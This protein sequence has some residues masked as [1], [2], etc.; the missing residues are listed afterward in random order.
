MSQLLVAALAFAL[1]QVLLSI[2]LLLRS[3]QR[4]SIQARLFLVFL[5]GVCGYL[6]TPLITDPLGLLWIS[7][8]QTVA[9]GTFWLFSASLFDDHFRLRP[10]K[11]GVVALTVLMPFI[12]TLTKLSGGQVPHWFFYALP[13]GI[14]FAL[15][16]MAL[17]EVVRCWREDLLQSRRNLR[18]WFA[19]FGGTYLLGMLLMRE[20]LFPGEP[21]L[22]VWQYVP[23]GVALLVVNV[24]LLQL[25]GG[26]FF[27]AA[28][29]GALLAAEP[30][31]EPYPTQTSEMQSKPAEVVAPEI[32]SK[33]EQLM[34]ENKIYREMG[35]TIGQLAGLMELPEYRLRKVINAGLGY[36]NFNDFLNHYRIA[37]A[38]Q[39]LSSAE[40]SD[41]P[42]LNIA[43]DVGYRSLSSFNKAFKDSTGLTPT[44]F[45]KTF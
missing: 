37:E 5:L 45:R 16:A 38:R 9:P 11:V 39:R 41:T 3:G 26:V 1:S 13:Q 24:L 4:R 31:A 28:E 20:V 6:L 17:V 32:L 19:G 10:W 18:L 43:L 15:L 21:W 33:L 42:I 23:A 34:D 2:I 40:E 30:E 7:A 36:R 29:D 27:V 12:G 8:L 44:E 22:A 14:E 25:R 35:L